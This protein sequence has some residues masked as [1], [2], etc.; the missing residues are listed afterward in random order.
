M[1]IIFLGTPDFAKNVLEKLINSKHQVVGVVCQPDKPVGRKQVLTAPP[2]KELALKHN[3]PVYQFNKIRIEGVE[4]LKKLNADIMITAA[5]GQ[6][7]SKEI[8]EIAPYGVFNVH[9]SLL[10]KYRGSSPIQW[11]LINGETKTGITI[12]KTDIGMDTG[13]MI[14]KKEIEILETDTV[15][16]L[17]E[18]LSM[19]G[20]DLILK[21]LDL[22]EN[23]TITYEKQ[24]E[25]K[26][27][28]FPML[29]KEIAKIDFNK[30]AKEIVDFVRGLEEWPTAYAIL[31]NEVLKVFSA[32][33]FKDYEPEKKLEEYT[34][35]EIVEC[36]SK[37]GL[38]VKV[39][40]GFINFYT[41]RLGN[42][43][44]VDS[45]SFANGHNNLQ[46]KVLG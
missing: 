6:L 10:P 36:S 41:I 32:K 1:K 37:K 28:Y 2:V 13:D 11:C 8:L 46:G 15:S 5:Y 19:I 21:A 43:K 22:L 40:D 39:K 3:I 34:N 44:K 25:N 12:M 30:S 18:K 31:E 4:P 24:D 17:F 45:K 27:T 20:G 38:I 29:S 14:L 26:A 23:G 16:S 7:L 9:G 42:G 33:I 35:G